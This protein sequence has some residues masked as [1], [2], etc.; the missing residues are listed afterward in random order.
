MMHC[1]INLVD[2]DVDLSRMARISLQKL[3]MKFGKLKYNSIA[4]K[5]FNGAA[6]VF[7]CASSSC[8]GVD[9]EFIVEKERAV[10]DLFKEHE[11]A[12]LGDKNWR[13]FY[14]LWTAKEALIKVVQAS[15]DIRQEIKILTVK[16]QNR[17]FIEILA[18]YRNQIF[19]VRTKFDGNL[20]FSIAHISSRDS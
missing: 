19:C 6:V 8:I 15:V 2:S 16:S 10:L 5:D 1:N 14:I 11:Y 18:Q 12:V 3:E 20:V 7:T 4:H 13:N 17:E 9:V